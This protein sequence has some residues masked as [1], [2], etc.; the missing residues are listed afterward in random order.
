MP[1]RRVYIERGGEAQL[2]KKVKRTRI[3][4]DSTHRN[5]IKVLLGTSAQK[6]SRRKGRNAFREKDSFSEG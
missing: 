3:E 1:R 5:Q 6:K 4:E 2:N